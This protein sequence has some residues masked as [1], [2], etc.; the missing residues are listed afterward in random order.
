[1]L[2]KKLPEN[3]TQLGVFCNGERVFLISTLKDRL[4]NQFFLDE[5]L[6]GFTF[7]PY[8]GTLQIT[9]HK[10]R[11]VKAH[12][13]R[14][15]QISQVKDTFYLTYLYKKYDI[16]DDYFLYAAIS[17]DLVNWDKLGLIEGLKEPAVI[18]S[19]YT[20]DGQLIMYLGEKN[21]KLAS[22][23]DGGKTW[24]MDPIPV[25]AEYKDFYG[26]FP[27]TLATSF[28]TDAGLYLI[29]YVK[30]TIQGLVQWELRTA[31]ADPTNPRKLRHSFGEPTWSSPAAWGKQEITPLGVVHFHKQLVSYWQVADQ[32]L[33]AIIHPLFTPDSHKEQSSLAQGLLNKIKT[34]P[35]LKPI[36]SH[37]WESR[38]VFNPAAVVDTNAVHLLYRAIGDQD[39]STIGLATSKDG[40]NIDERL[41]DPVYIPTQDFE[42]AGQLQV[43]G[44]RTSDF[45]SGGGAAGGAEDPRLTI[46]GSRVY[47]TYVAYNGWQAPR[48]ALTSI[49][50]GD[51]RT[52]SWNWQTPVLISRPNEVNKNACILPE[53]IGGKFVIFHRVYPNILIDFVDSL[54]EFD[55]K[56]KWL[57][58]RA[59][60]TPRPNAWDSRKIGAG[61]TPIKTAD[62]WL[63]IYQAVGERDPGRYKIGA[64]IL[65]DRD[66]SRVLYRSK[67]PILEPS[68]WYENEGYKS[69]VAYPCGAVDFRDQ[70]FV[71]YGGADTVV[72][73]AQTPM[74]QFLTQLK[75]G[76]APEMQ[77]V[78]FSSVN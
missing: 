29:Y 13:C 38:A 20:L 18:T 6:D 44:A 36:L 16:A 56:N 32:G 8:Q 33:V 64:M 2:D 78:K 76:Q 55:G 4:T 41:P 37:V 65:D 48:V 60:I 71:Y 17:D 51:F 74:S 12:K 63:L 43:P 31:I 73:A 28:A 24:Q 61:A 42:L 27:T 66:P 45:M 34:N 49:D 30:K 46:I 62:G 40:V 26:T 53:T 50:L 5:S 70:L 21:I 68:E 52:R 19:Y 57:E 9:D 23:P 67:T 54:D 58:T 69:G 77:Q 7:T 3:L 47:M 39:V 59:K 10:N 11:P 25:I 72:C 1:M 35:L 14:A 15:M 22:S 75:L